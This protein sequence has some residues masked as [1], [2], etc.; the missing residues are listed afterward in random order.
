MI[1]K[2]DQQKEHSRKLGKRSQT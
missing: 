1:F 2:I